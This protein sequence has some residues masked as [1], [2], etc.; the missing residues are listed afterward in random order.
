MLSIS[1]NNI[2]L[3][4]TPVLLLTMSWLAFLGVNTT[5]NLVTHNYDNIN[6]VTNNI[7]AFS[8]KN[9]T[10]LHLYLAYLC[11]N[12]N[13]TFKGVEIMLW[14]NHFSVTNFSLW[15][16]GIFL[17]LSIIFIYVLGNLIEL[18]NLIQNIDYPFSLTNIILFLP[19][20][21]FVNT[22]FTFL[23]FLEVVSSIL[24]YKLV[25]SKI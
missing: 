25:C 1:Y 10:N 15:W 13:I 9:H 16:C 14:Y 3:F 19:N 11:L 23:F 12:T 18:N 24:L 2:Y 22:L 8:K 4:T 5:N 21:F 17:I 6:Y 20:I 7:H